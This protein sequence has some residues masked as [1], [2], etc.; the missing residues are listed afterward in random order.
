[1]CH[2]IC[3]DNLSEFEHRSGS[4]ICHAVI[5]YILVRDIFSHLCLMFICRLY[6][7]FFKPKTTCVCGVILRLGYVK[8][9]LGGN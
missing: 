5:C 8:L 9:K 2:N 7:L 4:G 6:Y 1:M 3:D